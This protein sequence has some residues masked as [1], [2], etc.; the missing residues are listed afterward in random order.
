MLVVPHWSRPGDV[1]LAESKS[2]VRATVTPRDNLV[3]PADGPWPPAELGKKL[4][5]SAW[6]GA[7]PEDDR[8]PRQTERSYCALQSLNSEDAVTYSVFG[9]LSRMPRSEKREVFGR[10]FASLG[11][12]LAVDE[13]QVRFWTRVP[14]PDKPSA[15]TSGPELDVSIYAG[16][17]LV[18]GEAKWNSKI[19]IKQ[20]TSKE[21]D[22]I[23]LRVAHAKRLLREVHSQVQN[24]MVLAIGRTIE[25]LGKIA[26]DP[27]IPVRRITWDEIVAW[28]PPSMQAEFQ[29][30]FRWRDLYAQRPG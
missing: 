17:T 15:V 4:C 7:T 6:T 26:N 20:G 8:A 30:Y 3:Y 25:S 14:H 23:T 2:G 13:P 19:D 11:L 28:F 27:E 22:Q 29:D 24:V 18:I 21:R 10:M 1:T 9:T 5:G 16:D 12:P